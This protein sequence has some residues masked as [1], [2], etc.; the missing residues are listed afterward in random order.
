[1]QRKEVLAVGECYHVYNRG[2]D[3][4]DIFLD[5]ADRVRFLRLLYICNSSHP[6]L[7]KSVQGLTLDEIERGERMV[8]IGAY[9]LMPNHFHLLVKERVENGISRYM[10]KISTA[11]SMYFNIKNERSGSLF[12][13]TF[14]SKH[15][16]DDPYLMALVAY[17]H[18]NP[19]KSLISGWSS[20]D[21]KNNMNDIRKFLS[22]YKYSSYPD[23][24]YKR[25]F[26]EILNREEFPEYVGYKSDVDDLISGWV[27]YDALTQ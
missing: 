7:F 8:D 24:G 25:E 14:K 13:G 23:L 6:I 12:Q 22:D 2:V 9:C 10:A 27:E 20:N 11:Y 15:V 1:M 5:N 4:R 16:A 17:I 19:A 3:K 21:M 18:L 26:S